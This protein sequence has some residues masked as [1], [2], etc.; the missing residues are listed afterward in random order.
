MP[1]IGSLL[2]WIKGVCERGP[3]AIVW[4]RRDLRMK[5]MQVCPLHVTGQPAPVYSRRKE[6]GIGARQASRWWLHHSL[7]AL[8]SGLKLGEAT[9]T[10][11]GETTGAGG[12]GA[13]IGARAFTLSVV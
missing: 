5:T 8:S 2:R 11:G 10:S 12:C 9:Y 7:Q 3:V 4:Y 6:M 1:V 13:R